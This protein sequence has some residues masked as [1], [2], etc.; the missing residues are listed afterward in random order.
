MAAKKNAKRSDEPFDINNVNFKS[1]ETSFVKM[2]GAKGKGI[3]L[4]V[5]GKPNDA[6]YLERITQGMLKSV[7]EKGKTGYETYQRIRKSV[8][9][10]F[11]NKS[12]ALETD[13][14]NNVIAYMPSQLCKDLQTVRNLG[15]KAK[16]ALVV[17]EDDNSVSVR[18]IKYVPFKKKTTETEV[19]YGNIGTE[20]TTVYVAD[21]KHPLFNAK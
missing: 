12:Y 18:Y 17:S 8:L 5:D 7:P 4:W 19:T 9:G 11:E 6:T 16:F 15:I 2:W 3:T 21:S 1:I 13:K 14:R 20:A 10:N